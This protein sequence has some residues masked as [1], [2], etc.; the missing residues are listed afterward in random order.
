MLKYDLTLFHYKYQNI[1]LKIITLPKN[2][3]NMFI[4]LHFILSRL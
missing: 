3:S 2:E 1:S 4:R